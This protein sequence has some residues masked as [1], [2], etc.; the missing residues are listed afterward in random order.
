MNLKKLQFQ[1]IKLNDQ[2][3]TFKN[4]IASELNSGKFKNI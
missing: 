4:N 3:N 2:Q 1:N